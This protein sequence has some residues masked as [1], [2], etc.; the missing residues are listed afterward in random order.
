MYRYKRLIYIACVI[1]LMASIFACASPPKPI[2]PDDDS[3]A[4]SRIAGRGAANRL[5]GGNANTT[6]AP[7][8]NTGVS[9]APSNAPTVA[10]ATVSSSARPGWIENPESV[11][12]RIRYVFGVGNGM[13]RDMAE[14]NALAN[15]SAFFGQSIQAD[16]A[17][18][19]LYNEA[20]RSGAL[21]DYL[22][23]STIQNTVTTQT[24][25]DELIG[26]EIKEVWQDGS[27]NDFYALAVMDKEITAQIYNDKILANKKVIDNL[28]SISSADKNTLAEYSRYQYAAIIADVNVKYDNLLK[29]IGSSS[30]I[31]VTSG[32]NYRLELSNIAKNISIGVNVNG[33]KANR[34]NN[35][36]TKAITDLGFRNS[37]ASSRYL[38]DAN[39]TINE[40][41]GNNNFKFV[42]IELGISLRETAT[43]SILTTFS[44]NDRQGH[45]TLAEA[46]NRAI[47]AA[48]RKVNEEFKNHFMDC[49]SQMLP[50]K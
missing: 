37:G 40:T 45:A 24:S 1:V 25:M 14:K 30:S 3:A 9:S 21:A 18:T 47:A 26:A 15:L 48:E 34:I 44:F 29:A 38:F 50:K 8:R 4:R 36:L 41:P 13:N 10:Q 46:E 11:Y 39:I 22:E 16:Q 32:S 12:G 23:T 42:R 2:P 19:Y 28:V 31:P 27:K 7:T 35:A 20:I 6:P 5:E 43:N 49:L 17:N 33:D